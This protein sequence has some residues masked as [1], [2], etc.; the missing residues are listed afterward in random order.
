MGK[1]WVFLETASLPLK[2]D[3]QSY[4]VIPQDGDKSL[5]QTFLISPPPKNKIK[6]ALG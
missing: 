6:Q 1:E 2:V 3:S 4:I 5:P